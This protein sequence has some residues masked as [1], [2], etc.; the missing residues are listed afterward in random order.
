MRPGRTVEMCE[1]TAY[2]VQ[3]DRPCARATA[4][5]FPVHEDGPVQDAEPPAH[6]PDDGVPKPPPASWN[7]IRSFFTL[8]SVTVTESP[9]WIAA[10]FF[11][12]LLPYSA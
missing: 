1:A 9:M 3:R 10:P 5:L 4:W 12:R 6:G 8:T 7:S 2:D 11:L